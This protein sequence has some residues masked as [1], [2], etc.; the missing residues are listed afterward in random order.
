MASDKLYN[1]YIEILYKEG[2]NNYKYPLIDNV[3]FFN[4]K[5][6]Q[7]KTFYTNNNINKEDAEILKEEFNIKLPLSENY[8][9][10]ENL[11]AI[12]NSVDDEEKIQVG[13]KKEEDIGEFVNY[14]TYQNKK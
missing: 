12:I 10:T 4:H 2:D 14:L 11:N 3:S 1:I 9:T 7:N 13:K 8:I 6:I 5:H